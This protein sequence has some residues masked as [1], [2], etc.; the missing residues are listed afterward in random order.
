MSNYYNFAQFDSITPISDVNGIDDQYQLIWTLPETNNYLYSKI[1]I[2]RYIGAYKT[3]VTKDQI[4]TNNSKLIYKATQQFNTNNDDYIQETRTQVTKCEGNQP[5]VIIPKYLTDLSLNNF[6]DNLHSYNNGT[7]TSLK[8]FSN[9]SDVTDDAT[10]LKQITNNQRTIWYFIKTSIK[11]VFDKSPYCVGSHYSTGTLDNTST[12]TQVRHNMLHFEGDL[13]WVTWLTPDNKATHLNSGRGVS[14]T[15]V[16]IS[17]VYSTANKQGIDGDGG[18]AWVSDRTT[19]YVFKCRLNDG[20]QVNKYLNSQQIGQEKGFGVCIDISTPDHDCLA[21]SYSEPSQIIRCSGPQPNAGD[22]N[23]ETV[24]DS[25]PNH[26][27]TAGI[28]NYGMVNVYCWENALIAMRSETT[29]DRL[30]LFYARNGNRFYTVK[31]HSKFVSDI[32]GLAGGPD[33]TIFTAA[34]DQY[35]TTSTKRLGILRSCP[36]LPVEEANIGDAYEL[37]WIMPKSPN[38]HITCTVDNYSLWPNTTKSKNKYHVIYSGLENGRIEDL[39]VNTTYYPESPN[40]GPAQSFSPSGTLD[41]NH[42]PV[43]SLVAKVGVNDDYATTWRGVGIDGENNIWGL[44]ASRTKIY[45]LQTGSTYPLQGYCRYPSNTPD[46]QPFSYTN[47]PEVE[48]FLLRDSGYNSSVGTIDSTNLITSIPFGVDQSANAAWWSLVDNERFEGNPQVNASSTTTPKGGFDVPRVTNNL[49]S[50]FT[51]KYGIRMKNWT[52][53]LSTSVLTA[54]KAW[55]DIYCNPETSLYTHPLA[56]ETMRGNLSGRRLFPWY[57]GSSNIDPNILVAF[58]DNWFTYTT[59]SSGNGYYP[60][61]YAGDYA[62]PSYTISFQNWQGY[63]YI[64]SDF[65]GNLL[66]GG[67]NETEINKDYIHGPVIDTKITTE[68]NGIHTGGYIENNPTCYPWDTVVL[69]PTSHGFPSDTTKATEVSGY[70]DLTVFYRITAIAPNSDKIDVKH[71]DFNDYIYTIPNDGTNIYNNSYN[72]TNPSKIGLTYL[73]LGPASYEYLKNKTPNGIFAATV[74]VTGINYYTGTTITTQSAYNATVLERWPEPRLFVELTDLSAKR[75]TFF[76]NNK[77]D[78]NRYDKSADIYKESNGTEALRYDT[79]YGVDPTTGILLDRS[80]SRTYPISSRAITLS[81][82][83]LR[84]GWTEQIFPLISVKNMLADTQNNFNYLS[85][86]LLRYGDY[87]VIMNVAASTSMTSSDKEFINYIKVLEFEPFANFWA[88]SA[89][90]VSSNYTN[91]RP[92]PE[93]A[94]T[95]IPNGNNP[96]YPFISGYAPSFTVYFKDSSEAHTFPIDQYNWNF[97]DYY[98]EGSSNVKEISSNYYTICSDQISPTLRG[99]YN[100]GCWSSAYIGHTAAHTYIMPGTY[101]VTLTVRASTT[102]TTDTCARYLGTNDVQNFYVYVQEI[103]P[104][105][106][107]AISGFGST[108]ILSGTSPQTYYFVASNI[109]AGSFPICKML[110][111]FGDGTTT[112]MLSSQLNADPRTIFVSHTFTNESINNMFYTVAVSA[113]ACN[114]N[115]M[116]ATAINNMIGPIT[117]QYANQNEQRRLIGSKYDTDGNLVYLF[118]GLTTNET[119]TMVMSGTQ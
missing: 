26:K 112:T 114:T 92:T 60:G 7:S 61:W 44:G 39:I 81:T 98:N 78:N 24:V 16:D 10:L 107:G 117:N 88:V 56:I 119:Y 50:P 95:K 108:A 94:I 101:D 1:E 2:Y 54:I 14:R 99:S 9:L 18:Y 21:G 83:N 29:N 66:L 73:A 19:G 51:K 20:L 13:I 3:V 49:T 115:T 4:D 91:D 17:N 82:N 64:Y 70:D 5:E 6:T 80:I 102:N 85:S 90:S 96:S 116:I 34:Y 43:A 11:G 69:A 27:Y 53:T 37:G 25:N 106:T 23:T 67:S 72:Y 79:T 87:V 28:N 58:S 62:N 100:S 71:K 31:D 22:E 111:D 45:R 110:W 74:T 84:L 12:K 33:G 65:T 32:Y 68:I 103:P 97:G 104:V 35:N 42:V 113:F 63:S 105:F 57:G 52:P 75:L 46:E 86:F 47:T 8:T 76:C 40:G 55:Y 48:W 89:S 38:G 59:A 77:W 118:E 30:S 41:T 15:S 36:I 93:L 109:M